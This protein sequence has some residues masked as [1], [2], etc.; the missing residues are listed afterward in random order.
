MYGDAPWM[1]TL[2]HVTHDNM[3]TKVIKKTP[4]FKKYPEE[5]CPNPFQ[6]AAGRYPTYNNIFYSGLYAPPII[7]LY[8]NVQNHLA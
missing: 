8:I 1:G 2:R 7:N 6:G 5:D 4:I 3:V